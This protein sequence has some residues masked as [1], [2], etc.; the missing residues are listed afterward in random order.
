[1]FLADNP[2]IEAF[3]SI[4]EAEHDVKYHAILSPSMKILPIASGLPDVSYQPPEELRAIVHDILGDV[5]I[6]IDKPE[7]YCYNTSG[8]HRVSLHEDGIHVYY[9]YIKDPNG[10]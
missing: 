3:L 7:K 9:S 8:Q 4:I 5:D 10:N 6:T 1:M 2:I